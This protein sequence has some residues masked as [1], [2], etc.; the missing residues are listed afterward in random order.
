MKDRREAPPSGPTPGD[1]DGRP[2]SA[3]RTVGELL[4]HPMTLLL[5]TAAV[6]GL[7]VPHVTQQWQDHQAQLEIRRDLAARTARVVGEMQVATEL[8]EVGAASQDQAELDA[9]WVRWR[10][11]S[12][13]LGA[14]LAAYFGSD[15]L[16]RAWER[17]VALTTAHYVLSGIQDPGG[18]AQYLAGVR[19]A[20]GYPADVD[21]ADRDVLMARL[22]R[23]RAELV[24]LVVGVPLG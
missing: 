3:L 19:R 7:L 12:E 24:D 2:R 22:A 17:C 10:V 14:E 23:E 13:V 4:E 9:A 18:R 1:G 11:E 16:R 8:A 15:A 6:S 20:V 5:V 21:L